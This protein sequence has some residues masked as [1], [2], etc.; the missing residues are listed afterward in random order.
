MSAVGK[1]YARAAV[2][3]TEDEGGLKEVDALASGLGRFAGL[4]R[5]SAA[6]QELMDNPAL[7]DDQAKTLEA[8]MAKLDLSTHAAALLR[9]LA[10]R[11]RMGQLGE[12]VTQVEAMAD[13]KAGRLRARV[14]S[15]M[16][17]T[18]AQIKRVGAAL[19]RRLSSAVVVTVEVA[20]ELIGGLVCQVG[21]LTLDSSVRKQLQHLK[22]KLLRPGA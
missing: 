6:L 8:V 11:S 1:R 12:I 17:L 21:D 10:E 5:A 22:E 9:L 20:P 14:L 16:P 2:L 7:K 18:D 13:D 15:P 19:E 4:L 3:A